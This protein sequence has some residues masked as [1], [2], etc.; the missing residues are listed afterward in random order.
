MTTLFLVRHGIAEDGL[1]IDDGARQLTDDGRRRMGKVARG[2]KELGVQPQVFLAS[3]L[4]R[5]QQTAAIL[6]AIL[7]PRLAVETCA[8]LAIGGDLDE[9]LAELG[10]YR[11]MGEV[12]LVGHQPSLGELASLLLTGEPYRVPLPFKKGAVAA[13]EVGALPPR[14]PGELLWF[15]PS[16][17]LRGVVA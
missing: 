2:L 10:A 12:M 9:V 3:P 8:P 1:G 14:A 13:I 4:V 16:K 7:A 17:L 11:G 6:A 15:V 5:A